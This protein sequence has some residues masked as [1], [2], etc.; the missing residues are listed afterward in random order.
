MR[1][2]VLLLASLASLAPTH[3][4]EP[5]RTIDVYVTP[6]YSSAPS[7]DEAP[8]VS[9]ARSFDEALADGSVDKLNAVAAA[10]RA[11]SGMITPMTM[12]VLAIRMYEAGMR[13]EAVFWFYVAKE[14][15][16]TTA[17]VL[18]FSHPALSE[19]RAAV[20]SF[21]TLAGPYING[22]AFC[23]VANQQS[24]A[25]KAVDWVADHPY[26]AAFIPSLPAQDGDRHENMTHAIEEMRDRAAKETG[27]VMAP[28]FNDEL[29][30]GR[31]ENNADAQ[32]C[33]D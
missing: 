16:L 7:P 25:S 29:A 24:I 10:I 21:A 32:F 5:A 26:E 13:D 12:M 14:R 9:V 30:R 4:T 11:D 2:I 20:A 31:K 19:A 15:F 1:S 17:R 18:D 33:W 27:Y 22:Y 23:D 28:T 3:A 6:Y 8:Q